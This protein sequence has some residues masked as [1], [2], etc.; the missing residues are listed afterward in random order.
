[1][2]LGSYNIEVYTSRLKYKFTINS[3]YTLIRGYSGSGKTTLLNMIVASENDPNSYKVISDVPLFVY[4]NYSDFMMRLEDEKSGKG[5]QRCIIFLDEDSGVLLR[6]NRDII[7]SSLKNFGY[8]FVICSRLEITDYKD[9][10]YNKKKNFVTDSIPYNVDDIKVIS[11]REYYRDY[12]FLG[13][14]IG[15]EP[16]YGKRLTI[17]TL[18]RRYDDVYGWCRSPKFLITEDSKSGKEFYSSYFKS[19]I[20]LQDST[21]NIVDNKTMG[22]KKLRKYLA[23]AFRNYS[24]F[25]LVLIADNLSFGAELEWIVTFLYESV[26]DR[27]RCY[28]FTPKC[29][30]YLLARTIEGDIPEIIRDYDFCDSKDN[31]ETYYL[32]MLQKSV[33]KLKGI[34]RV[35]NGHEYIEK[36]WYTKERLN[37]GLFQILG[38]TMYNLRTNFGT[39]KEE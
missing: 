6:D 3:K 4:D 36:M 29:F 19:A 32:N 35:S 23:Y 27:K 37:E 39:L 13:E 11:T 7:L 25:D 34:K 30:E 14:Y 31:L 21:I 1:M 26:S 12:D 20:L 38:K 5:V 24:D 9:K 17:N 18:V 8:Y 15:N 16:E 22:N 33:R 28:I 2:M 10:N